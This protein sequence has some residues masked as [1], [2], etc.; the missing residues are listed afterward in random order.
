MCIVST[1]SFPVNLLYPNFQ[2]NKSSLI[3]GFSI[4]FNENSEVAHFLGPHFLGFRMLYGKT[5]FGGRPAPRLLTLPNRDLAMATART[6]GLTAWSYNIQTSI[7]TGSP[8]CDSG[9]GDPG[10]VMTR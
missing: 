6:N 9:P 10:Q 7:G 5:R 4:R 2:G 3:D 8:K 1:D